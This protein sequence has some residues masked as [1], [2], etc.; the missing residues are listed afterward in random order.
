METVTPDAVFLVIFAWNRV[1][2][3]FRGHCL[4]ERG[5][6]ESNV[7]NAGENLFTGFDPGEVRRIVKGTQRNAVADNV[8][9]GLVD[10]NR[11]EHFAASVKDAVP[12]G[13]DFIEGT[14]DSVFGIRQFPADQLKSR[15][16]VWDGGIVFAFV[17]LRRILVNDFGIL[18]PETFHNT[19][20]KHL[21]LVFLHREQSELQGGTP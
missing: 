19:A 15:I 5:I 11:L 3:R 7:R 9:H 20:R 12:D 13:S 2:I 18:Q 16:I 17:L 10:K 14:D 8:L 21:L 4:V 1:Q 6:E